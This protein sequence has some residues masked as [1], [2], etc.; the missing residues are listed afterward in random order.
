MSIYMLYIFRIVSNIFIKSF[1]N[2][3]TYL[4]NSIV[5]MTTH[6]TNIGIN[7]DIDK[8][9]R[10]VIPYIFS[11]IPIIHVAMNK[12]IPKIGDGPNNTALI[13]YSIVKNNDALPAISV[14]LLAE[15]FSLKIPQYREIT[16]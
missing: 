14:N 7:F 4:L 8:F 2:S 12:P 5:L 6:R 3:G 13:A 11:I 16:L 9:T 10:I 15:T 1:E